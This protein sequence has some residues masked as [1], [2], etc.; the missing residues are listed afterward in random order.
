MVWDFKGRRPLSVRTI[1]IKDGPWLLNKVSKVWRV[2]VWRNKVDEKFHVKISIFSLISLPK[3]SPNFWYFISLLRTVLY[4][5]HIVPDR[6]GSAVHEILKIL[7]SP[8]AQPKYRGICIIGVGKMLI[9]VFKWNE[10]PNSESVDVLVKFELCAR[11]A[12]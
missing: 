9:K 11:P 1:W 5:I 4:R 2:L 3:N 7:D 12:K 6:Q 10:L 8:L